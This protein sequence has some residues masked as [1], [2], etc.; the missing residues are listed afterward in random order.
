[1]L[2]SLPHPSDPNPIEEAFPKIEGILRK[3]EARTQE[4]LV[5]A[6]GPA[7][8]SVTEKDARGFFEHCGYG[9]PVQPL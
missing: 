4:A 2:Y 5:E 6:P 1:L 3:A 9:S 7:L 8:P